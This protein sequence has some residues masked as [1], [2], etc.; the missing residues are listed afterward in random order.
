MISGSLWLTKQYY[1]NILYEN[2]YIII[3]IIIVSV[4]A[5]KKR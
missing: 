3:I 2:K 5:G 4:R 1:D